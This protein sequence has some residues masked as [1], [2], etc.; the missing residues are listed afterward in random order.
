MLYCTGH[1]I[2]SMVYNKACG[3]H[4]V[5]GCISDNLGH[6]RL[7]LQVS[8]KNEC[9]LFHFFAFQDDKIH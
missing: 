6:V 5:L 4:I 1:N 9:L 3:L 8:V 7:L 2:S